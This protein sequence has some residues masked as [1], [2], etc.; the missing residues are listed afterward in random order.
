M[1]RDYDPAILWFYHLYVYKVEHPNI[2]RCLITGTNKVSDRFILVLRST[3]VNQIF[4]TSLRKIWIYRKFAD[5][6]S[7]FNFYQLSAEKCCSFV[8]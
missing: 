8:S 2:V 3:Y 7:Y 4:Y 1:K 6:Y 5:M